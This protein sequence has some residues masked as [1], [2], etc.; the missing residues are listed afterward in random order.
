MDTLHG[1]PIRTLYSLA[2]WRFG[3]QRNNDRFQ[4]TVQDVL[5]FMLTHDKPKNKTTVNWFLS[6]LRGW[7]YKYATRTQQT[8]Y[9]EKPVT[10]DGGWVTFA[11]LDLYGAEVDDYEG[12][13]PEDAAV[14]FSTYYDHCADFFYSLPEMLYAVRPYL[15][16]LQYEVVLLSSQ[17]YTGKEIAERKGVSPQY[18]SLVLNQ[19]RKILESI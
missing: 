17:G 13:D 5:E 7:A 14:S 3:R 18:I 15:T 12:L 19:S 10:G 2:N 11:A 16:E 6:K 8:K 4:D 9:G 1:V